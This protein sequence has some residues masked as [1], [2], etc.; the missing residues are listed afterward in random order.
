MHQFV[1]ESPQH[2]GWNSRE[3]LDRIGILR[4]NKELFEKHELERQALVRDNCFVL[5]AIILGTIYGLC[6]QVCIDN[7]QVLNQDSEI[8]FMPDA[9]FDGG[10]KLKRWARAIGFALNGELRQDQ[11]AD[12]LF[13]LF[14]AMPQP[15]TK[16]HTTTPRAPQAADNRRL[17]LGAQANGMVAVSD[18]VVGMTIRPARLS[19]Y[20]IGRGQILN[21]PVT[22]DGYLQASSYLTPLMALT[23][24]PEPENKSLYPF[25]A[26]RPEQSLRIDIEPCWEDDPRTIVFRVREMG[27]VLAPVNIMQ[28][29]ESVA[30]KAV[31][32]SC[33]K[34]TDSVTVP[35][36]EQWQHI[37]IQQLKRTLFK[38]MSLYRADIDNGNTKVLID[39]SQSET[40]TIYA[41]GILYT[42]H[43]V[44]AV[45]CLACAYS[46]A[47][48]KVKRE[49]TSVAIVIP[50]K[51]LYSLS[52]SIE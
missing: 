25:Q 26:T 42:R 19:Y 28:V 52:P 7:G 1:P 31:P 13:E 37:T 14:L 47:L 15:V 30:S 45:E 18:L 33:S 12:L 44:I 38:G 43:L 8:S 3:I 17:L 22:E 51:K 32:C 41:I 10:F 34:K 35:I 6:S 36:A 5:L 49:N 29:V 50:W 20:H 2:P 23:M 40:V 16:Q 27:K 21:L 9:V 39:A 48:Q 46:A 11:W 4:T 24:D